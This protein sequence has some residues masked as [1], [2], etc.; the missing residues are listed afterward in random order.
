[1]EVN[2]KSK[3]EFSSPLINQKINKTPNRKALYKKKNDLNDQK[4]NLDQK[5]MK[6]VLSD[7]SLNESRLETNFDSNFSEPENP[8]AK[9]TNC[10]LL[11]KQL[12]ESQSNGKFSK[13]FMFNE[14]RNRLNRHRHLRKRHSKITSNTNNITE[15]NE[16]IDD[17]DSKMI[18]VMK[19]DKDMFNS[20]QSSDCKSKI[21]KN[22]SNEKKFECSLISRQGNIYRSNFRSSNLNR[23]IHVHHSAPNLKSISL[24]EIYLKSLDDFFYNEK[25]YLFYNYFSS[26]M[27]LSTKG[28][29]IFNCLN[30][31]DL[32][33]NNK[34]NID[35]NINSFN[36]KSNEILKNNYKLTQRYKL[37]VEGEVNLCRLTHT[38][39]VFT[40]L[41]SS[42]LLRRWKT[43]RLF[44][45]NSG[46]YSTTVNRILNY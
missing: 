10:I 16:S 40:K 3:V 36:T 2:H 19:F 46:I 14:A 1:M 13:E 18:P 7:G 6:F 8:V 31:D 28:Q 15:S 17:S 27:E 32:I 38:K 9:S 35:K 11:S 43:H 22:T 26:N 5:I 30:D 23:N 12:K 4:N 25:M 33:L 41:F 37:I 20:I 21:N 44:L 29:P 45:R 39:N 34:K 42:K 24:E